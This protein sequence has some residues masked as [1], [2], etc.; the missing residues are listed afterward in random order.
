MIGKKE[1]SRMK[2][3]VIIV[4]TVDRELVDEKAMAE[5]I[6]S[7]QVDTYVYEGEDLIHTPLAKLENVI[8]FKGFAFYTKEALDNLYRIWVDNL[9]ALVKGRPQNRIV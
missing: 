6:K 7:G 9:T 2:R 5:A 4:N 8:G 1:L 3:G